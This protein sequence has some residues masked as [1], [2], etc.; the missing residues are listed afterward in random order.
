MIAYNVDKTDFWDDLTP[1]QQ[2]ELEQSLAESENP[3][4]LV[5]HEMVKNEFAKWLNK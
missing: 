3:E 2:A 5:E 4:N 1:E